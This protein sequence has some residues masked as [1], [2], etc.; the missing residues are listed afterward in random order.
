MEEERKYLNEFSLKSC[1][2]VTKMDEMTKE[3][4][5]LW[6]SFLEQHHL[7]HDDVIDLFDDTEEWDGYN[8]DIRIM[9]F[10]WKHN[11]KTDILLDMNAWPGDNEFGVVFLNGKQVFGNGDQRISPFNDISSDL[12]KRIHSYQHIRIQS[13][14]EEADYDNDHPAHEHCFK[15]RAQY[16]I[17]CN[18]YYKSTA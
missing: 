2:F 8:E 18:Q 14:A 15:I 16:D 12:I 5:L 4:I 13:C 3:E 11:N 7:I 6:R 17:I 10:E 1:K 9:Y